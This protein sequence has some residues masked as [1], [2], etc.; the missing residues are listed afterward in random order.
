MKPKVS[1]IIPYFNHGEYINQALNSVHNQGFDDYEIILVN[2]SSVDKQSIEVFNALEH[3]KVRKY[4]I[5]NGGPCVAKNYGVSMARGSI[6]GFLDSDN[7]LLSPYIK[8]AV[9]AIDTEDFEWVF[10]DAELFGCETGVKS[11]KLKGLEEIFINS[12]IDNCFFIKKSTFES[13]GGF[14]ESLSRLGL[15]DWELS[16]RLIINNIRFKHLESPLFKY[17]VLEDSRTNKEAK[18]NRELIMKYVFEKHHLSL[19]ENYSNMFFK[20]LKTENKF[21]VKLG[22]R[23]RRI[24]GK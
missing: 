16:V 4:T 22:N 13:I 2:D 17:R 7:M 20:L 19:F 5:S 23:I 6:L 18:D 8:E 14:D 12:V 11:Q 9:Y 21:E 3:S 24:L 10:G 15:E 1:I